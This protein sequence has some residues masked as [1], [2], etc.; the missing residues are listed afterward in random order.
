[1]EA[2]SE[3]QGKQQL[4]E[5]INCSMLQHYVLLLVVNGL[6]VSLVPQLPFSCRV[7]GYEQQKGMYMSYVKPICHVKQS[8]PPATILFLVAFG[9]TVYVVPTD[10]CFVQMPSTTSSE[11]HVLAKFDDVSYRTG[12]GRLTLT[13]KKV[14]FEA[15]EKFAVMAVQNIDG[16]EMFIFC[17]IRFSREILGEYLS[18][19]QFLDSFLS[20]CVLYIFVNFFVVCRF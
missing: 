7:L 20:D 9:N 6:D 19:R 12:T 11:S 15:D 18:A 4:K 3:N 10:F 1:M 16:V 8:S 17:E 5:R 2:L 14:I 13:D